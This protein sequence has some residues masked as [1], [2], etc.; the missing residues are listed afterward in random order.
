M[1]PHSRQ[2]TAP[3]PTGKPQGKGSAGKRTT[4]APARVKT[5]T[6]PQDQIVF[7]AAEARALLKIGENQMTRLLLSGQLESVMFGPRTRR[8]PR[9][10]LEAFVR[11]GMPSY[12]A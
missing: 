11:R 3:K 1:L 12:A 5:I 7:T 9:E 4:P 6:I 10:A 8:I 2:R